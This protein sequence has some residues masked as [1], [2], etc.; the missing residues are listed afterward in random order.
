MPSALIHQ[1]LRAAVPE[2]FESQ[3]PR[4]LT[5]STSLTLSE[6]SKIVAAGRQMSDKT[7]DRP[8]IPVL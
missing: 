4:F 1:G 2:H 5:L 6:D 7:W 3:V 8:E